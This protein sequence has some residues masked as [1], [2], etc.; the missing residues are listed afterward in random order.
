MVRRAQLI[1][2]AEYVQVLKPHL[3]PHAFLPQP[4]KLWVVLAHLVVICAGYAA[5]RFAS[6]IVLSMAI[7]L[8]IGHSL[9]CLVFLAHELS[10]NTIIRHSGAR[11]PLEVLL[12][13]LNLIPAT[14]WRRLHNQSH[15]IYGG[16]LRDPDRFFL[17]AE[18][19]APDGRLRRLYTRLFFPHRLTPKWNPLVGFHFITYVLRHLAAVFYPGDTRPT[20]VTYKPAYARKVRLR[21]FAEVAAI[22]GMQAGIF[23]A[24]G[25][26]WIAYLW[27]SP[28]AILFTSTFAMTYI[29]TNHYLHGLYE[30]HDPVAASTSVEVPALWD[31]LHSNF[32][33]HAEHH[34]FPNM[35]GDFYPL[36][37]Q[38]LTQYYPRRYH[39]IPIGLAWRLLWQGEQH[40]R[41]DETLLPGREP[42]VTGP[43]DT[44]PGYTG[45][46]RARSAAE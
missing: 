34:L 35:S 45:P 33:Y 21:I 18:L 36:V 4:R 16:T 29:W 20:V 28:V 31:R 22:V 26:D 27:A 3:P 40:I 9:M 15:H 13:G 24:V 2:H 23:W 10:H 14:M 1:S 19:E 5:L 17:K 38:L 6:S 44:G 46:S 12:W 39:R 41:E 8:V 37:S 30:V 42:I 25:G 11:Y 43:G 7:A 32:S